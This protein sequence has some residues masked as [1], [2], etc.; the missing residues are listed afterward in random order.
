MAVPGPEAEPGPG[1]GAGAEGAADAAE[2]AKKRA[3]RERWA[4][5]MRQRVSPA[6]LVG[7]AGEVRQDFFRPTHVVVREGKERRRWGAEDD[8]A[9]LRGLERHGVGA[10]QAMRAADGRLARWPEPQLRL[11]ASRLLGVQNLGRF[12]AARWAGAAPAVEA[13]RAQHRAVGAATGCWKAGLLVENDA[14]AA[15]RALRELAA[16]G[17]LLGPPLAPAAEEPHRAGERP[18]PAAK[19]AKKKR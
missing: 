5:A 9:L 10:W 14:G 17:T 8:A 1:A 13:I 11:K 12:S 2:R 6:G 7:P 19:K 16:A 18:G 3:E 4:A 15:G